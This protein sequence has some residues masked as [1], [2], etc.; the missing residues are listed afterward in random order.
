LSFR[1]Y[2]LA[3]FLFVP[4]AGLRADAQATEQADASAPPGIA[5][6]EQVPRVPGVSTLL[7][8]FNAGVTFSGVH[9]SSIGWFTVA[10]PA[11]SYTFSPHYSADASASVYPTRMVENQNPATSSTQPLVSDTGDAGDTF[12]GLHARFNPRKLRTMTTASFTIPTGDRS[13]GLGAG[14]VTFDFSEHVELYV[15]QVGFLADAGAGD[16]S[17]LFNR[18]VANNYTSVGPLAH[19]QQ[20]AIFWL[21]SRN[22]I[23]V[24]AYQ[25]LPIGSQTVYTNPGIAGAPGVTVVSGNGVY[26]DT[27]VTT[28]V[29]IPLTANLTFS[30]Y[31]SRSF[32]LDIDTVSTGITYVLRGRPEYRRL[33]MIDR[34]IR[35]A[36]GVN[37]PQ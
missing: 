7:R 32:D 24:V 25:Q 30:S 16:S 15:R 23:E 18:L 2:W 1:V 6:L 3:V 34:A 27:G 31:Y 10:T 35:E 12:I 11:V 13:A 37:K 17:A 4:G 9:D 36:E 29:S 21:F 19:F 8:G 22:A 26:H 5:H 20:G 33:S 14:R 28:S